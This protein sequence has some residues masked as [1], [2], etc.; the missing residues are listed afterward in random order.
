MLQA[1]DLPPLE[2]RRK[3]NRLTMMHKIVHQKVDLPL[4]EHLQFNRRGEGVVT[5]RNRNPLS[6]NV[7]RTILNEL[8]PE[9]VLSKNRKGMESV[10]VQNYFY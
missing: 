2:D 8:F 6:L 5:T 1:L 9:L 4:E 10:A 7:P 3:I